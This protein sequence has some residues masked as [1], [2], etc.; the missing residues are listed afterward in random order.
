MHV[1]CDK[2]VSIANLRLSQIKQC[3]ISATF[4]IWALKKTMWVFW[5]CLLCYKT[6]DNPT[7]MMRILHMVYLII[8]Y[9]L[10]K[11]YLS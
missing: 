4:Q 2:V 6:E 1:Q 9:E 10:S 7:L 3:Y 8:I 5:S 11:M